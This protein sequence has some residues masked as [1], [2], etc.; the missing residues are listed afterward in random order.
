MAAPQR[1]SFAGDYT[2]TDCL[3]WEG[4]PRILWAT[5]QG[6]GYLTPPR[7]VMREYEERGVPCYQV[8]FVVAAHPSHPE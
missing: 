8:H 7:Y 1:F 4:F 2:E 6:V 3:D 5:L